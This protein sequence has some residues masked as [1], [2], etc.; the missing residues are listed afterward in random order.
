MER[1]RIIDWE[2]NWEKRLDIHCE[3][4]LKECQAQMRQQWKRQRQ[5]R[6]LLPQ[7]DGGRLGV[8]P[9]WGQSGSWPWWNKYGHR[10]HEFCRKSHQNCCK[11]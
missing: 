2:Y 1:S 11:A 9:V 4:P 3:A 8:H 7:Y 6:A 5:Q 10:Y